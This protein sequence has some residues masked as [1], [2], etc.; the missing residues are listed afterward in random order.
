[1]LRFGFAVGHL[2]AGLAWDDTFLFLHRINFSALSPELTEQLENAIRKVLNPGEPQMAWDCLFEDV[3]IR[4]K[5]SHSGL[6]INLEPGAIE[7]ANESLIREFLLP[8]EAQHL[9]GRETLIHIN[10]RSIKPAASCDYTA[11]FPWACDSF[12]MNVTVRGQPRYLLYSSGMR[13]TAA[14]QSDRQ[15]ETKL[16]CSSTDLILPGSTIQFDW[17]F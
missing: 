13:G 15:H 5:D 6:W 10:F 8:S 7:I 9:C 16:Q 2:A 12:T 11:V 14:I 17:G 1:M 3:L 4:V